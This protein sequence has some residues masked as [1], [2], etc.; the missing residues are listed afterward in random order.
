M[1]ITIRVTAN[2]IIVKIMIIRFSGEK[3]LKITGREIIGAKRNI[4][5]D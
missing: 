1:K 3:E 2:M 4:N 5:A